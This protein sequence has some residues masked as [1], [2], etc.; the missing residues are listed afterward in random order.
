MFGHKFKQDA[1]DASASIVAN[2]MP[3]ASPYNDSSTPAMV[4]FPVPWTCRIQTPV[5]RP[6]LGKMWGNEDMPTYGG[7]W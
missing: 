3:D 5:K 2:Q 4:S 6:S 1:G 7:P